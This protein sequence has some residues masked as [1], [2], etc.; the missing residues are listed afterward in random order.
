MMGWKAEGS[1]FEPVGKKDFSSPVAHTNS[2]AY[3]VSHPVGKDGLSQG[4]KRPWRE[5][6]HLPPTR[7]EAKNM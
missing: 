4:V 1:E 7:A 2:G 6:H 3:P 5:A